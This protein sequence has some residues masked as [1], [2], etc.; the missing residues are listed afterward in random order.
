MPAQAGIQKI[1]LNCAL[2]SGL[3]RNDE[4]LVRLDSLFPDQVAPLAAL[5]RQKSA[6]LRR[7]AADD[8]GA[9]LRHLF[10]CIQGRS[11]FH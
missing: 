5:G 6:K 2:D 10:F 7:R 9:E 4:Y 11:K 1:S 8:I 3:R